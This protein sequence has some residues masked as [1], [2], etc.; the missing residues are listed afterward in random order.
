MLLIKVF[1]EEKY[2]DA[3]I[4]NGE[5]FCQTIGQFKGLENDVARG[6]RFEAPSDW[7][8]PDRV[9]VSLSFD[10]PEG[11]KTS[12]NLDLAGPLVFLRKGYDEL[13][14]YCMYAV[15]IPN[16]DE[17]YETEE[18]RL[19][20]FSEINSILKVSA[21][22]SEEMLSL[23]EHAVVV[24][25]VSDYIERVRQAAMQKGYSSWRGLVD[26]FDPESFHGKFEEVE[27]VFK[28]RDIYSYQNEFRFVFDSSELS[29]A[30]TIHVGSLA[31]I[32]LK[33]RTREINSKIELRLAESE[34]GEGLSS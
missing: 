31:G 17:T 2:A 21:T 22:L 16:F 29:G 34:C 7:Y 24:F 11:E 3:F 27:A 15:T 1:D 26:Y 18:E 30:K 9:T 6:D 28:K 5:M 13:N 4:Q 14:A 25:G 10:T 19:R 33:M 23:G 20:L 12:F 8:Q 32:A